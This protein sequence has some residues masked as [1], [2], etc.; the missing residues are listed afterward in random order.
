[1]QQ[2]CMLLPMG[3]QAQS[4]SHPPPPPLPPPPSGSTQPRS[5][6]AHWPVTPAVQRGAPRK[7]GLGFSSSPRGPQSGGGGGSSSRDRAQLSQTL[8]H[9]RIPATP[10]HRERGRPGMLLLHSYA[11]KKSED[12]RK[13]RFSSEDEDVKRKKKKEAGLFHP[14]QYPSP[15]DAR[16]H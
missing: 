6:G 13:M 14:S 12:R 4:A 16:T 1:M 8:Q 9:P 15:T 3:M 7:Q 10:A 5:Q 11:I 2:P